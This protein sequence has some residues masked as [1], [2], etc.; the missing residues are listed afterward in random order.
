[1]RRKDREE[2]PEFALELLKKCEYAVLSTVNED[3]SPYGIP[4]SPVFMDGCFYFH[5]APEGRKLENI[6]REPRVGLACVGK[7]HLIPEQFTTEYE[8]AVLAG[9]AFLVTNEEEKR[10]ALL[11]LCEK[12]APENLAAAEKAIEGSLHRT[13]VCRIE[14]GAA[15]GKAKRKGI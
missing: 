15:T 14:P 7:T 10:R 5:C 6:R 12:Y 3:G 9:S 2:T 1:M 8:S 13:G 11:C 4:I